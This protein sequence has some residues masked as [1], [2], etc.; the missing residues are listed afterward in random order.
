MIKKLIVI[1]GLFCGSALHSAFTT[2]SYLLFLAL[3]RN[4]TYDLTVAHITA[5]PGPLVSP[6]IAP[7]VAPTNSTQNSLSQLTTSST[8]H[9][10]TP[11]IIAVPINTTRRNQQYSPEQMQAIVAAARK[12]FPLAVVRRTSTSTHPA[13]GQQSLKK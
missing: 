4:S 3:Q 2:S 6:V 9:S 13:S 12:F 10:F 7:F 1:L 8:M 11:V 5:T